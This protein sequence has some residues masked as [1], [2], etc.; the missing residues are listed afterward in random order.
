[1]RDTPEWQQVLEEFGWT[2]AF[3]TGEDFQAFL[4]EQDRRVSGTLADLGLT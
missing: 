3:T 2:D 4:Q 1:M